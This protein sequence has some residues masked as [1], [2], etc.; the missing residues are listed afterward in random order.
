MWQQ[1]WSQPIVL[2][3]QSLRLHK[4]RSLLT[5]LGVVFGVLGSFGL[6]YFANYFD[7]T[8]TKDADI[9]KW[10]ELPV[11]ATFSEGEHNSCV[12]AQNE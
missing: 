7:D 12:S 6:A 5:M 2:G 10:L 9:E 1:H 11:L 4:L 8:I 3:T